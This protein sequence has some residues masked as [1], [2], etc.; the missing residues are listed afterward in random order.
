MSTGCSQIH[1]Q[2]LELISIAS[3]AA[4]AL[5]DDSHDTI[6]VVAAEDHINA[7]ELDGY[8]GVIAVMLNITSGGDLWRLSAPAGMRWSQWHSQEAGQ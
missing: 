6:G 2:V 3:P 8:L 4:Q 7:T 5:S 1:A